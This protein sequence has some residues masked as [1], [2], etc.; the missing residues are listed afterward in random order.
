MPKRILYPEIPHVA[1]CGLAVWPADI[2]IVWQTGTVCNPLPVSWR[3][4][5]RSELPYLPVMDLTLSMDDEEKK[6][7]EKVFFKLQ[8]GNWLR[9]LDVGIFP[10]FLQSFLYRK[11]NTLAWIT[12]INTN[13]YFMINC[14]RITRYCPEGD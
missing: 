5:K 4:R 13:L 3:K 10:L 11:P 12:L 2:I 9:I 8:I 7:Q 6:S 14:K 1:V